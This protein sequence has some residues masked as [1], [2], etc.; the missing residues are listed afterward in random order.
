MTSYQYGI[1][2]LF[3]RRHLPGKPVVASPNVGCFLRLD[4]YMSMNIKKVYCDLTS[5][6]R[7]LTWGGLRK[8]HLLKETESIVSNNLQVVFY[9]H[10]GCGVRPFRGFVIGGVN[11]TSNSWP[12][13][14]SLRKGGFHSCGGSLIRPNWVLTAA[15]CLDFNPMLPY[16]VVVGKEGKKLNILFTSNLLLQNCKLLT[17]LTKFFIKKIKVPF[18]ANLKQPWPFTSFPSP[19]HN[20]LLITLKVIPFGVDTKYIH[21]CCRN[22]GGKA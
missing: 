8:H 9:F 21:G 16:T 11:A 18:P 13:I 7:S 10:V 1:S 15:H 3:L 17:P 4:R 6:N 22:G 2:A 14:I 12:W 19:W 5:L 20:E